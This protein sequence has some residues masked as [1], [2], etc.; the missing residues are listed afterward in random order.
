MHVYIFYFFSL[1]CYLEAPKRLARKISKTWEEYNDS[2]RKTYTTV[3]EED[4]ESMAPPASS[5]DKHML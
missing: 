2:V 3:S 1:I 5:K 4:E